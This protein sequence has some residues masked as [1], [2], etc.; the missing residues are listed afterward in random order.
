MRKIA[1]FLVEK[2]LMFFIASIVIAII[3]SCLIGSVNVNKD[4]T[5]YLAQDS[6]MRKG[7][8]IINSEFPVVTLTDTFQIMFEN[9]TYTE[10]ATIFEK[11]KTYR[12][13]TSVDYDMNSTEYNTKTYTMYMVT[14]EYVMDSDKVNAVIDTIKNDLGRDY[15]I[16][17]YYGNGYLD[18]LDLL[19]PLAVSIMLI[20]LLVMCKS[21]FEPVLLLVSIGVAVL[22]N[23]G[24]NIIFES[25]SDMTFA[26][27]AVFQLVLSIDY[28]IILMHRYQ[29][30]FDLLEVK[31]KK[32]AMINAITNAVSSIMSSS[33][34]TIVGLLVLLLMTFTIGT[35]IGL[36]LS[37]G[38][39]LSLI[40]VFTVMP[41]M[42]LWFEDL[43]HKTDKDYLKQKRL[44]KNGGETNV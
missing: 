4:Q 15:T 44:A 1:Q 2:R 13:V 3:F 34:T 27:A 25:V 29:Q 28:S 43:I 6:D 42:I 17:T 8:D 23:M 38:V 31:D 12:G 11:L 35:D 14:T 36:V 37:K 39:L 9:L 19:I 22:I 20:L 33:A 32:E 26:I 7:L 24:S 10:K 18:V 21:Y 5:K 40:C 30:E 41:S 16:H